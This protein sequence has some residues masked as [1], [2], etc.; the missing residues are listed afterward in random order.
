MEYATIP[1]DDSPILMQYINKQAIVPHAAEQMYALVDDIAAY[2]DFLPWCKESNE[3]ER[4]AEEV[5]A[6]IVLSKGLVTQSFTTN[7]KN[8][9]HKKIEMSLIEGPFSHLHGVW[10]F[11]P[12][13]EHNSK[14]TLSM[15]FAISNPVLRL[16]LEPVFT[17][18][19]SKLVNAFKERA[20]DVYG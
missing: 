1:C 3:V 14:V 12:L 7:N 11:V 16:T 8:T 15:E 4:V 6:S 9:E 17:A 5:T 2:P 20:K 10:E 19:L 18:V 13:D